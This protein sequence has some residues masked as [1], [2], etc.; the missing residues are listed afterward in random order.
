MATTGLTAWLALFDQGHLRAGQSALV[1]G[2]AGAVGSIA[3][4]LARETGAYGI[5][6][7]RAVHRQAALDFG[8]HEFVDLEND[9]LADV[10]GVSLAF[11]VLGGEIAKRSAVLVRAGGRIVSVAGPL[12]AV[13]ADGLA[14]DLIVVSDRASS[15]RSPS[16]YGTEGCA[17]TSAGWSGLRM[18][19]SPSTRPSESRGR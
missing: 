11:D 19:R 8:A 2:E 3:T 18:L 7:G 14:I 5:G 13:P 15:V 1:H 6:T 4:Q 10:R 16:A 17:R 12:E 9:T